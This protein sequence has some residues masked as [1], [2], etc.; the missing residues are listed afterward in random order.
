VTLQE[1]AGGKQDV[2]LQVDEFYLGRV[3]PGQV[4]FFTID[5]HDYNARIAKI[6][7]QIANGTFRVDLQ[8]AAGPPQSRV[9]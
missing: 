6:Y 4:A 5:G 7:P 9:C 2:P 3:A 1:Q 8:R